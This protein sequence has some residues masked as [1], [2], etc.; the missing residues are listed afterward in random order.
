ML[1][2]HTQRLHRGMVSEEISKGL[3]WLLDQVAISQLY[4]SVSRL[5]RPLR[6]LRQT[7]LG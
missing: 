7:A 3:S 6:L 1:Y 4:G 2:A 5:C